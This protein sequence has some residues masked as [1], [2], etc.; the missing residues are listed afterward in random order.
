MSSK[1]V[2]A[3]QQVLDDAPLVPG[4][5]EG[6]GLAIDVRIKA[7]DLAAGLV[8]PL[9]EADVIAGAMREMLHER[10]RSLVGMNVHV[11]LPSGEVSDYPNAV[12]N[13]A[14]DQVFAAGEPDDV[15]SE[16][17]RSAE[18]LDLKVESIEILHGIQPAPAV[19]VTTSDPVYYVAH[20]DQIG[21]A[22]FGGRARY[23]GEYLRVNDESGRPV[24]ISGASFR[25]GAGHL[26]IRPDLNPRTD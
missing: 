23:E 15:V 25:T 12:G 3:T 9:W 24:V 16:L 13:V 22:L 17:T 4:A 2:P 8:R 6:D 19:T 18:S 1:L 11:V 14:H 21:R 20:E 26:W 10:G 5:A 7:D